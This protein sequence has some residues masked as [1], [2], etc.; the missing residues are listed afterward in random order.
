MINRVHSWL[1]RPEKGWD[2]VS[3]DY[4]N[5]YGTHEWSAGVQEDLVNRL[6]LHLGGFEGKTVLD[7]GG[8]PGQY[9]V[10]F[11][12]R[13]A[14][15]T[16]FDVSRSY[17]DFAQEKGRES[18]VQIE[19]ALGYMDDARKVLDRQ[20]HLVFNRI[21]WYYCISDG[22][23]ADVVYSLVRPAGWAYVDTNHSGV[24][25]D[26]ANITARTR[27]WLNDVLGF[28]IG[29]P[30]PPRGRVAGLFRRYPTSLFVTD[31]TPRN[32]RVLFQ[33]APFT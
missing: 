10:A 13:G 3:R 22:S 16:W 21:C 9:S 27:L 8:G 31:D 4:A 20:F 23:F 33:K 26:S 29:H 28:K 17:L 6:E 19:F 2:P 5:E 14:A 12:K 24:G 30:F 11:A 15:V 25:R 18:Q 1:H 32:D 7:L